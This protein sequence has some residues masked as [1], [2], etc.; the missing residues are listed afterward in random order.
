MGI[1]NRGLKIA[2]VVN[3]MLSG[4][5]EVIFNQRGVEEHENVGGGRVTGP[6]ANDK[7]RWS[8]CTF[9]GNWCNDIRNV[10]IFFL[11]LYMK[12]ISNIEYVI[13]LLFLVEE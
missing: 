12:S 11:V 2:H 9:A 1:G 8:L 6:L 13:L 4:V 7:A 3:G 10:E 5:E